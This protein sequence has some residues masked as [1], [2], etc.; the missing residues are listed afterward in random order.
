M[1]NKALILG[2]NRVSYRKDVKHH[3]TRPK[4]KKK[5]KKREEKETVR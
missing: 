5:K 2:S 1:Q 3:M 4:K